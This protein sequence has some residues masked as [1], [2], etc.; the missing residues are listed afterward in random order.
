[1]F[2]TRILAIVTLLFGGLAFAQSN[3]AMAQATEKML[4]PWPEPPKWTSIDE[5][6]GVAPG[7]GESGDGVRLPSPP[8]QVEGNAARPDADPNTLEVGTVLDDL[9]GG[10]KS[11]YLFSLPSGGGSTDGKPWTMVPLPSSG[12]ERTFFT[13]SNADRTSSNLNA[14]RTSR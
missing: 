2:T 1:M 4:N 11:G 3:P 8:Q 13:D 5:T 12:S 9:G 6:M 7:P 10:R 14:G